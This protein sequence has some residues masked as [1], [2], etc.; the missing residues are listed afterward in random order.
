MI[1]TI[2]LSSPIQIEGIQTNALSMREPSVEDM[3]TIKKLAQTPE[4]QELSTFSNLCQITPAAV[5][6]LKWKDYR[7]LQKVFSKMTDD[8]SPL[9][10]SVGN[11]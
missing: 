2:K 11:S 5:R 7:K 6:A 4:E 1:E 10:S 3:L 9:E 8:E